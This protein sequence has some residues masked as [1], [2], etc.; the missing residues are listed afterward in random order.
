MTVLQQQEGCQKK[1]EGGL[2]NL[3]IQI[4]SIGWQDFRSYVK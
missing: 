2:N 4:R 3:L 1:V